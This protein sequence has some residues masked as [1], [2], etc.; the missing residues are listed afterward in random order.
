MSKWHIESRAPCDSGHDIL[1]CNAK[2]YSG[3]RVKTL[4]IVPNFWCIRLFTLNETGEGTNQYKITWNS[5]GDPPT[6]SEVDAEIARQDKEY[7][8]GLYKVTRKTQYP[9]I[10]DQLDD[11]YKKGAFSDDMTAKLK[12]VKD[13]NPKP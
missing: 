6:Q 8:D 13:D 2:I 1:A 9:A 3:G 5:A 11:L 7:D 12:K 4:I 10:G